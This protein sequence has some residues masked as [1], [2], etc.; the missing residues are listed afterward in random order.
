[1]LE[2]AQ[3]FACLCSKR[4]IFRPLSSAG[5]TRTFVD[6]RNS[7]KIMNSLLIQSKLKPVLR[8]SILAPKNRFLNLRPHRETQYVLGMYC[9]MWAR[10][11]VL[12]NTLTTDYLCWL[13]YFAIMSCCY[14]VKDLVTVFEKY[15]YSYGLCTTA[16]IISKNKRFS[17]IRKYKTLS[18][19]SKFRVSIWIQSRYTEYIDTRIYRLYVIYWVYSILVYT[20]YFYR[21]TE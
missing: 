2:Y 9:R 18:K 15:R 16:E 21:Y 8:Q 1:M 19:T 10:S 11:S 4:F 13:W 20:E 6:S 14:F 7:T 12:I 17:R 3:L 5:S